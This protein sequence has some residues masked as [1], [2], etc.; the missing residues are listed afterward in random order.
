M[1]TTPSS[2]A[3]GA[4]PVAQRIVSMDVLRGFALFGIFA[5]NVNYMA[6][7]FDRAAD[8]SGG[9]ALDFGAWALVT[10]LCQTKFFA[11][12]STLFGMGLILQMQR[13]EAHGRPFTGM[14]LRRLGLLCVMGL[15]HG[16]FLF[17]GDILFVY[18]IAGLILFAGRKWTP[19][20]YLILAALLALV[21]AVLYTGALWLDSASGSGSGAGEMNEWHLEAYGEGPLPNTIVFNAVVFA[22]WLGISTFISFNWR[23]MSYFFIGA[24]LMKLG[25]LAPEKRHLHK[26]FFKWGLAIG[27][28]LEAL[29]VWLKYSRGFQEGIPDMLLNE[30]GSTC[31]AAGY[32]GGA[33][34]FVASGRATWLVRGIASAGRMALTNYIAQSVIACFVFRWYGLDQ[35]NEWGHAALFVFTVAVWSAQLWLSTLWL[36]RFKMGPLEAAWRKLTYAGSSSA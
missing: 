8:P 23:V 36:A 24:A 16:V 21:G 13:A 27:L 12:F 14:Y 20:T 10:G 32:L 5:V 9:S 25:F 18:S 17:F 30:V 33:V 15:L 3:S 19:R 26:R 4:T 11:L 1:P 6:M 29:A 22:S 2:A 31:L 7:L 34:L 28:P 35:F